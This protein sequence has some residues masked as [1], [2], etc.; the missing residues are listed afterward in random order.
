MNG[1]H[2]W[3]PF[4]KPSRMEIGTAS[5]AMSDSTPSWTRSIRRRRE[6]GPRPEE[7][8]STISASGT[9]ID[10][11]NAEAQVPL[12]CSGTQGRS[13]RSAQPLRDYPRKGL[14]RRVQVALTT[15][16][17]RTISVG[18][19]KHFIQKSYGFSDSVLPP[20]VPP[21]KNDLPGSS[22]PYRDSWP[23][24][25]GHAPGSSATMWINA[26]R[27]SKWAQSLRHQS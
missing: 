9:S 21:R 23:V 24:R 27:G 1:P 2:R 11:C 22:W 7:D 4:G 8:R 25:A 13:R 20:I 6:R 10:G 12:K 5:N 18:D 15:V 14:L 16:I 19:V 17:L 26:T 3:R